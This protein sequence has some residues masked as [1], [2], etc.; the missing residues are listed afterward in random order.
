MGGF[1][2]R[3]LERISVVIPDGQLLTLTTTEA[4]R[5]GFV[6][7][8][9]PDTKAFEASLVALGAT[10][11]HV[12][13]TAS[14]HAGRW[15]LGIAGVL[16][17]IVMLCVV[18]SLYQG[19]GTPAIV[20]VVALALLGLVTATA[21]LSNGLALF[22]AGLGVILL[23]VEAFVLPGFTIAGILGIVAMGAGFL[24]LATGTSF[25]HRGNLS[26][27]TAKSFLLQ[28]ILA[29]GASAAIFYAMT[30]VFPRLPF[31][32]RALIA[33]AQGL[34]AFGQDVPLRAAVAAG[35]R[36]VASTD[37]R[38]AGHAKFDANSD[39]T[40]DVVSEGGFIEAGTPLEV[41]RVEGHRV[42]VRPRAAGR[43]P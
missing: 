21:D 10:L 12:E 3:E 18:M 43:S 31:G 33:G 23:L 30:R 20:G 32:G 14:E 6:T 15:L 11:E 8:V 28:T 13:M 19:I 25:S 2:K 29:I 34:P 5:L 1:P 16:S 7:R 4:Q 41:V 40:V 36:G 24:F 35:Q 26:F 39:P 17:G 9:F 38:P 22:L 37:L 42:V 27:E